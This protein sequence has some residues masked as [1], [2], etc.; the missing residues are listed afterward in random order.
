MAMEKLEL[1]ASPKA[2]EVLGVVK[3]NYRSGKRYEITVRFHWKIT[4]AGAKFHCY[5]DVVSLLWDRAS[6]TVADL[7]AKA[8]AAFNAL[9]L[10][11]TSDADLIFALMHL[12]I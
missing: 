6:E 1:N 4:A 7:K 8:I 2:Y 9:K 5:T 11:D 3:T 12:T 10:A